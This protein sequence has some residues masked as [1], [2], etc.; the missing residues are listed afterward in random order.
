MKSCVVYALERDG[1][2]K[3]CTHIQ[4]QIVGLIMLSANSTK[5][6]QH[7]RGIY[8]LYFWLRFIFIVKISL[9]DLNLV[10]AHIYTF[11]T[12]FFGHEVITSDDRV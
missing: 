2:F 1:K 4:W 9:N 12:Y 11:S 3:M 5:E 7:K 10:Y 8:G 6:W